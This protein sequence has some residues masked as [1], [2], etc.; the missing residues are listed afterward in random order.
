MV[1][2][3]ACLI[4]FHQQ[5]R[6]SAAYCFP[7]RVCICVSFVRSP[8]RFTPIPPCSLFPL[9]L[10]SHIPR[11]DAILYLDRSVSG[12]LLFDL[13]GVSSY[14]DLMRIPNVRSCPS[15]C[16]T[17]LFTHTIIMQLLC[18]TWSTQDF[19]GLGNGPRV[20]MPRVPW[21]LCLA[22]FLS[23]FHVR[24]LEQ[25]GTKLSQLL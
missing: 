14:D 16:M 10:N 9:L 8:R 24:C 1:R 11:N 2:F 25:T 23:S 13:L 21:S 6:V 20:P 12:Q 19:Q 17:C 22:Q 4:S 15:G 3:N 7:R 5:H 18:G